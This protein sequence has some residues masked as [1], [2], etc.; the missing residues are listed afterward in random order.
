MLANKDE[1]GHTP[2]NTSQTHKERAKFGKISMHAPEGKMTRI[3]KRGSK[4][5]AAKPC[6]TR[7]KPKKNLAV[8]GAGKSRKKAETFL[9][10]EP[11]DKSIY[12]WKGKS[13]SPLFGQDGYLISQAEFDSKPMDTKDIYWENTYE[14]LIIEERKG[15]PR[16]LS[17]PISFGGTQL[18]MMGA[19]H[20]IDRH[21]PTLED[22]YASIHSHISST[23]SDWNRAMQNGSDVLNIAGAALSAISSII[24]PA[25]G[26]FFSLENLVSYAAGVIGFFVAWQFVG[27]K[28]SIIM[29][30]RMQSPFGP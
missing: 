22:F 8:P 1:K 6:N 21:V 27:P 26:S 25:L 29:L 11:E 2:A 10:K 15:L 17:I 19:R 16:V 12:R 30:D 23:I 28:R 4:A 18:A 9:Y 5:A 14:P 3:K 20:F 24:F 13:I 7:G